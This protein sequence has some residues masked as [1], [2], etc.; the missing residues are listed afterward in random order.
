MKLIIHTEEFVLKPHKIVIHV[1][2]KRFGWGRRLRG[3]ATDHGTY[4]GGAPEG[5]GRPLRCSLPSWVS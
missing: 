2:L 1:R 3:T 4:R 5:I